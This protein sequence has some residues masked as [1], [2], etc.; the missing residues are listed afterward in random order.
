MV[1]SKFI[2]EAED[3]MR[4]GFRGVEIVVGPFEWCEVF[5]GEIFWKLFNREAGK[6]VG[7]SIESWGFVW[8]VFISVWD[9]AD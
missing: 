1:S 9:D 4:S 6:I 7:H 2:P 8:G 5:N 3:A